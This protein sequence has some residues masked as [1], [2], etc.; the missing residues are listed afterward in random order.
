MKGRL[1]L[2]IDIQLVAA[3]LLLAL[4]GFFHRGIGKNSLLC[5]VALT[6][7]YLAVL[8]LARYQAR[9]K[10]AQLTALLIAYGML[11]MTPLLAPLPFFG[12]PALSMAIIAGVIV[13]I[14]FLNGAAVTGLLYTAFTTSLCVAV[15][16]N[17]PNRFDEDLPA[18][19]RDA[20]QIAASA[21]GTFLV[22]FLLWDLR[23]RWHAVLREKN[24]ALNDA[25][26]A[27]ER[28]ARLQNITSELAQLNSIQDVIQTALK[29]CCELMR[30]H[31]GMARLLS[32]EPC[33]TLFVAKEGILDPYDTDPAWRRLAVAPL[34]RGSVAAE[35]LWLESPAAIEHMFAGLLDGE[36]NEPPAM[37]AVAVLPL[38]LQDHMLGAL[39][40]TFA[41]ARCF[42]IPERHFLVTVAS[43]CAQ[44]IERCR[45]HAAEVA[46]RG[47][48]ET[49][50]AD[51]RRALRVREE[52]LAIAGHE[53]RTPLTALQLQIQ[54]LQ[55]HSRPHLGTAQL[56]TWDRKLARAVENTSRLSH[57][58][59][60]LLDVSRI[61][62][63]RL[64]LQRE[65]IDL[66]TLMRDVLELFAE[67][68]KRSGSQ[69]SLQTD[70]SAE[71]FW[72]RGR[73]EQV[74][75]NLLSNA[76]K[77]GGGN[78][79]E[80]TVRRSAKTVRITVRDH[81]IGISAADRP[82]IFGKFERAVSERQYGGL[83]IGLWVS[84]QIV[85]AHGGTIN[86]ESQGN[87]GSVFTIEL[88]SLLDS[89]SREAAAS[90]S[91]DQTAFLS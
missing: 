78:E 89:A 77:Y 69:L 53:L 88:P 45:L 42:A 57:L 39:V 83:G 29:H 7:I 30:A 91:D 17:T 54:S 84:Q 49:L 68:I 9:S 87:T 85:E 70:H 15:L 82:R 40:L 72:D 27:A 12:W 44:A 24:S 10:P 36:C 13:G 37:G 75:T 86:L 67:P 56:P 79:I 22:L 35:S 81:G 2:F 43:Q 52:F 46:A 38:R 63:G 16:S 5:V 47:T 31:G 32:P 71:G 8:G 80:V 60:V 51:L 19:L 26:Q 55:R 48:L 73:L 62:T 11:A 58:V 90:T 21:L 1:G 20:F 59:D 3:L 64:A 4:L 65:R 25:K 76:V 50:A 18:P 74:V 34:Q 33:D 66:V 23:R 28:N 61:G 41:K 14:S 6:M